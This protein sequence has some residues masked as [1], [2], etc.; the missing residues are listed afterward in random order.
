LLNLSKNSCKV[1]GDFT[2]VSSAGGGG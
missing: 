2:W 1:L